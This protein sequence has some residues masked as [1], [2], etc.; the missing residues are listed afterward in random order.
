MKWDTWWDKRWDTGPCPT[1]PNIVFGTWDSTGLAWDSS[2]DSGE[3]DG[4]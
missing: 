1:V 3:T 4:S 2:W